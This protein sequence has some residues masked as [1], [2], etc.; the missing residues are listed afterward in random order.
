MKNK[1]QAGLEFMMVAIIALT[2]LM[3]FVI[4]LTIFLT[5]EQEE[6]RMVKAQNFLDGLGEE[7]F[8]ASK[9]EKGYTRILDLP[10]SIDGKQY[11]LIIDSGQNTGFIELEYQNNILYKTIPSV[12]GVVSFDSYSDSEIVLMKKES[13]KVEVLG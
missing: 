5:S 13:L 8:F 3:V 6:S 7:I 9:A 12:E 11:F 4:I 2:A 1:G 10:E